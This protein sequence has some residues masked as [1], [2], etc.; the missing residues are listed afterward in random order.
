[1]IACHKRVDDKMNVLILRLLQRNLMMNYKID[2]KDEESA[3]RGTASGAGR[4]MKDSMYGNGIEV[5]RSE[6]LP[7]QSGSNELI[8]AVQNA[9]SGLEGNGTAA[10]EKHEGAD[11][12]PVDEMLNF[13]KERAEAGQRQSDAGTALN[14][15][16]ENAWRRAHQDKLFSNED[17]T[18]KILEAGTRRRTTEMADGKMTS[19]YDGRE[20][21][22][23]FKK[24]ASEPVGMDKSVPKGIYDAPEMTAHDLASLLMKQAGKHYTD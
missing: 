3:L 14:A 17:A 11:R 8:S 4:D 7:S 20:I 5:L 24:L 2:N 19:S 9:L 18:R 23:S 10:S 16:A 22:E 15:L 12:N 13:L 6:A 1:M 21:L